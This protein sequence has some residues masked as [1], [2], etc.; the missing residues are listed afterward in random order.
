MTKHARCT[1]RMGFTLI[2]LLVVIS[3]IALLIGILLPALGAA[4]A[5]AASAS[6]K[7]NLR[8]IGLG[9]RA[10][11]AEFKQWMPPSD[12]DPT[13][14]ESQWQIYLWEHYIKGGATSDNV[15]LCDGMSNT[16]Y[17][18]PSGS[19]TLSK[20]GYVM[21]VLRPGTASNRGW[22]GTNVDGSV[23]I[24]YDKS[25]ASGWTGATA[26]DTG[27][28]QMPLRLDEADRVSDAIFVVDHRGDY[29]TTPSSAG[30][31]MIDGIYRFGET[32]HS[33]KKVETSGTPRQKV[34]SHHQGAT[35]N[36]VY[37][38]GHVV[39]HADNASPY[40]DWVASTRD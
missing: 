30:P 35:F 39:Q 27:H 5:A 17:Y 22:S 21:N 15:F 4:R 38:D 20:V 26:S 2:E 18:D 31:D 28:A 1:F 32:D 33:N 34:G 13:G 40:D 29:K 36:A 9:S 8:Q 11:A 6:C 19:A 12:M 14:S 25:V 3:I 10:Y 23:S 16:E 24:T 37:G 7:S